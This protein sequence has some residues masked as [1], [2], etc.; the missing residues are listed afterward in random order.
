MWETDAVYNIILKWAF[1]N[2]NLYYTSG[3]IVLVCV[4][5]CPVHGWPF[6]T[7]SFEIHWY[8]VYTDTAY[9]HQ[10]IWATSWENLFMQHTNNKGPDQPT[11]LVWSAPLLFR[12]LDSIPLPD[13]A[14]TSRFYLASEPEQAGL[15]ITW[16]QTPKTGFLMMRLIYFTVCEDP[17]STKPGPGSAIGCALRFIIQGSGPA[18]PFVEIWSWNNF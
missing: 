2:A 4:S 10:L 18:T 9:W 13:T 8:F 1:A 11:H 14:E 6:L 17:Y 5:R 15:S 12:C 3:I 16:S 7:V